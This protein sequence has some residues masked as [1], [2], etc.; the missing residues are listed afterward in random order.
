[1]YDLRL[2]YYLKPL[3]TP[4]SLKDQLAC[5]KSGLKLLYSQRRNLLHDLDK[6]EANLSKLSDEAKNIEVLIFEQE[7][8]ITHLTMSG[9]RAKSKTKARIIKP[10]EVFPDPSTLNADQLAAHIKSLPD[11]EKQIFLTKLLG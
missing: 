8:K 5:I 9:S 7:D 11:D 2:E 10:K 3:F 4:L 6:V 1:M